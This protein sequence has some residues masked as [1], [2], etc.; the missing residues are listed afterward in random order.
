MG[1]EIMLCAMLTSVL[2]TAASGW[3]ASGVGLTN[4]L[5]WPC[6]ERVSRLFAVHRST[7]VAAVLTPHSPCITAGLQVRPG[8]LGY[9]TDL[10]T[11]VALAVRAAAPQPAAGR[12]LLLQLRLG[13]VALG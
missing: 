9:G 3:A 12:V 13:W 4:A 7:H 8:W 10:E 2:L 11:N 6:K 1:W 5:V